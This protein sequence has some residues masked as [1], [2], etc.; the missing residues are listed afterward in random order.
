MAAKKEPKVITTMRVSPNYLRRADRIAELQ[1]CTRSALINRFI[2]DGLQR[3][4]RRKQD[5][6]A[7]SGGALD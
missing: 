4:E 6:A 3:E 1:N 2:G 7:V 5:E